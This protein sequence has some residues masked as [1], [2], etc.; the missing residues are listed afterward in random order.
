MPK[1]KI[2]PPARQRKSTRYAGVPHMTRRE[3]IAQAMRLSTTEHEDPNGPDALRDA[4]AAVRT[5][6]HLASTAMPGTRDARTQQESQARIQ[7]AEAK[8]KA[9][10]NTRRWNSMIDSGPL[11]A[12]PDGLLVP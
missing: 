10:V 6:V 12:D 11:F 7:R 9:R 2:M 3:C 1:P 4:Q 8:R 5:L